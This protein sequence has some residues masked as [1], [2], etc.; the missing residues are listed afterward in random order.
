MYKQRTTR[1]GCDAFRVKPTNLLLVGCFIGCVVAL[2]RYNIPTLSVQ[3]IS[4]R[5]WH[6]FPRVGRYSSHRLRSPSSQDI[7]HEPGMIEPTEANS[8]GHKPVRSHPC[9][10]P[11]GHIVH[12]PAA[13]SR[14]LN[15]PHFQCCGT[16]LFTHNTATPPPPPP[17]T[18]AVVSFSMRPL[19]CPTV[20]HSAIIKNHQETQ[21]N[22]ARNTTAHA[23]ERSYTATINLFS[24]YGSVTFEPV[25]VQKHDRNTQVMIATHTHTKHSQA[26][27]QREKKKK[28]RQRPHTD[29]W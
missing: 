18:F 21:D 29:L 12:A 1:L 24:R 3:Q 22:Q 23:R 10:T 28:S 7:S 6:I 25:R 14:G 9:D 17:T 16:R 2:R 20:L 26:L 13:L 19:P 5:V 27:P 15:A 8:S 11:Q 4:Y